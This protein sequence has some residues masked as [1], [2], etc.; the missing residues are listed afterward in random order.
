MTAFTRKIRFTVLAALAVAALALVPAS[1]AAKG[2]G[3]TT[4]GGGHKGGGVTS[5]SSYTGTINKLV[6]LNSTDGLPHWG[7]QITFDV[8]STA[9]YYAVRVDCSQNGTLVYSKTNGFSTG[10]IWGT[11]YV[12]GNIVWTG[13][14]ADCTGTLFSQNVDGT[15]QQTEAAMSFHVYS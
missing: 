5:G 4:G 6:L 7:Q 3:G 10:W 13:G 12:L 15:N 14:D 1:L 2:G 11:T 8:T 9:P